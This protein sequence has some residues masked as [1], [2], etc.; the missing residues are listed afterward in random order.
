LQ[1]L[2]TRLVDGLLPF[3]EGGAE[4]VYLVGSLELL[5]RSD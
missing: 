2:V 5:F 4:A 1:D 3:G